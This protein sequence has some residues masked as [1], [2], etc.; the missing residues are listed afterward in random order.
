MLTSTLGSASGQ[1]PQP[2][3]PGAPQTTGM[4]RMQFLFRAAA[5]LLALAIALVDTFTDFDGAVAVL[6]VVVVLLAARTSRRLDIIVA[7]MGGILVTI[8]AYL[9]S[10]GLNHVGS[11]TAR[12][13]VSLAAIGITAL[14]A[15][16]NQSA[17]RRLRRRGCSTC[18]TT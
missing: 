2:V 13:L 6:Y 10:H 14:L 16:Q 18:R 8:A 4:R 9:N 5:L 1:P 7:G 17:T 12:A 11:P 15:L 3:R